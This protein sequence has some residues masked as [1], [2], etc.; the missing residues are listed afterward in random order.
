MIERQESLTGLSE[1]ELLESMGAEKV[2]DYIIVLGE[3][4]TEIEKRMNLA[5]EILEGAYGITVEQ[6]IR[7][8]DV[9]MVAIRGENQ[10]GEQE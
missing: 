6:V 5:S 7:R 10:N 1:A 2:I 3:K 8:R 9:T 4:I